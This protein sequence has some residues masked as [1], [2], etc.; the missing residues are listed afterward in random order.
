MTNARIPENDPFVLFE[1]WYGEACARVEINPNAMTLATAD[2]QGRPTARTVLLK[3]WDSDG[4]VFYTNLDSRKGRQITAN[5]N[6]ALLFYWRTL[7]RQIH[8][9]GSLSPVSDDEADAYF[10]TRPRESQLAAWA[11]QQS[12]PMPGGRGEFE[13]SLAAAGERF[14]GMAVPRPPRWSGFRLAPERIEFWQEGEFRM[15]HRR[16]FRRRFDGGWDSAELYP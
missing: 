13:E 8:I 11:S 4:F 1:D 12:R 6:A 9:E 16:E 15:H 5:P 3:G 2:T 10:A 7:A 14:E